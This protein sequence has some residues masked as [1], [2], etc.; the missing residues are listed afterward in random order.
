MVLLDKRLYS[1]YLLIEQYKYMLKG[2]QYASKVSLVFTFG[3]LCPLL[4][5]ECNAEI[6]DA[7]LKC[8]LSIIRH[9]F[10]VRQTAQE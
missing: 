3:V 6:F 7:F 8:N 1:Q 10:V 4:E 2:Q 9:F 5:P